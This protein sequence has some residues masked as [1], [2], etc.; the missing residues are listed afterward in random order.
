[1]KSQKNNE[2]AKQSVKSSVSSQSSSSLTE[3]L[4]KILSNR[5]LQIFLLVVI[6]VVFLINYNAMFDK[7]LD[8][9]GD[10]IVYYSLGKSLHDG[11]GYSNVLGFEVTPHTHF[12][13][14][15]PAF[16]SVLLNFV[17]EGSFIPIKNANG[18]LLCFSIFLLFYILKRVTKNNVILAFTAAILFCVQKDLLRWA[19]IMMSEMLF[20]FLTVLIIFTALLLYQ[21]KSFKEYKVLDY[22]ALAVMVL[23]IAYVYFVRTMGLSL[24]LGMVGW[25]AGL[26][27]YDLF[28][29]LKG[30]KAAEAGAALK[31]K[32]RY[33]GCLIGLVI[34]P[35]FVSKVAWDVRNSSI[36]HVKS[37]YIGDFHKKGGNGEVMTTF[38]DWTERVYNNSKSYLAKFMPETVLAKRFEFKAP[39]TGED[40]TVGFVVFA[41]VMIGFLGLGSG[42]FLLFC[43]LFVTF[44]V[45]LV[46]PEQF[47]SVRYYVAIVPFLLFLFLHGFYNIFNFI[48]K[49]VSKGLKSELIQQ[50][51]TLLASLATVAVAFF[52]VIP[53]QAKAQ[54]PYRDLA[55]HSYKKILNDQNCLNFFEALDWCKAN[56]PDS[57]RMICR[58]P[59]LYYI[60]SGFKHSV[61]FPNYAPEDT[62]I[63]YLNRVKAT[64]LILDNWFKHAYTT[65]YPAVRKYPEKFKVIHKIADVDTVNKINPVY[66]IQYNYDWGYHGEL[67]NGKKEGPG[68]FY[69]Q[70]GRKY[71]GHYKNDM[72][73]GEGTLFDETGQVQFDGI[74]RAGQYYSG[75]GFSYYGD[76][77]YTGEYREGRPNG[78]GI[79]SD[80]LGHVLAKGIWK[81]GTLIQPTN[82]TK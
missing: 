5:Y 26:L 32:L 66:I 75:K 23:S 60:N 71:V 41:L 77:K 10:N 48:L 15:Y 50:N 70:D 76:K 19:T 2:T 1:M 49:Y 20:L 54:E 35:F 43:Y 73:D 21:K 17:K 6:G 62:I 38:S 9:N 69:Y 82:F 37:D 63:S 52:W 57:A 56:M 33:Y 12:P 72:P 55:K 80:T 34:V 78:F 47:S 53:T 42:G 74:W 4:Q 46:W 59:E 22:I 79:Y 27:L 29:Y 18:Y 11:T 30:G 14:G 31:Q 65:L 7:K 44:C 64:H 81:D 36:G 25:L 45:L 58:K 13:P 67:V 8:M 51:R 61:S 16:I 28:L 3:K 40:K 68:S 24:I 39:I